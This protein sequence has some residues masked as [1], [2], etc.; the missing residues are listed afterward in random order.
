M[1][2][3]ENEIPLG[4]DRARAEEIIQEFFKGEGFSQA[5]LEGETV[6]QKGFGLLTAPQY[7]KVEIQNGRAKLQAW[8]KFAILPG[9]YLGEFGTD[10]L[11]LLVPRRLLKAKVQAL[12]TRLAG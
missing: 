7:M 1:S 11:F 6:W 3:Y 12:E 2:R 4:M 8:I 9:V 5:Q 10:G